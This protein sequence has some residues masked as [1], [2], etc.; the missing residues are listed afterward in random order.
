MSA[1]LGLTTIDGADGIVQLGDLR[2]D[3]SAARAL[4][5]RLDAAIRAATG[6]ASRDAELDRWLDWHFRNARPAT[7]W[8]IGSRERS[9]GLLVPGRRSLLRA[10]HREI[11]S[12]TPHPDGRRLT[13]FLAH[14]RPGAFG[15]E[16]EPTGI[17][18]AVRAAE[19][20]SA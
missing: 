14:L 20:V 11:A 19:R 18:V 4:R 10:G 1:L 6:D 13:G 9:R 5:D 7:F 16:S 8:T 2:L 15:V 17:R 12:L 3:V